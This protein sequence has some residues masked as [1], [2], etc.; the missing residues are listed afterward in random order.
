MSDTPRTDAH[1]L[2]QNHTYS[3]AVEPSFARTLERELEEVISK[4]KHIH[5]NNGINDACK[6]CGFDLRHEI[7]ER[8]DSK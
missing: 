8:I 4:F 1:L 7:H 5:V 3:P 2:Q 6:Q